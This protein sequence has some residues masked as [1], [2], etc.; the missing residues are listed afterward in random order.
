M[1]TNYNGNLVRLRERRFRIIQKRIELRKQLN[2]NIP[3]KEKFGILRKINSLCLEVDKIESEISKTQKGMKNSKRWMD[4]N[5]N[6]I[7]L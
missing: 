3:H 7:D 1:A 5:Y 6:I 2:E 4:G